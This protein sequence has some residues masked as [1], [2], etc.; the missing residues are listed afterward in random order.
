MKKAEV[1][2]PDLALIVGT[3]AMAGAGIVLLIADRLSNPRG[4]MLLS[5]Y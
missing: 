4:S 5:G 2:L 1:T 3:L